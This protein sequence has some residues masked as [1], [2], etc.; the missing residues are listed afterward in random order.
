MQ[1]NSSTLPRSISKPYTMQELG[2]L[3]IRPRPQPK[4]CVLAQAA[5]PSSIDPSLYFCHGVAIAVYVDD[6]VMIGQ[7]E[8]E[9]NNI[10][11]AISKEFKVTDEGELTRFLGINVKR[12]GNKL[13]CPSQP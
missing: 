7:T 4:F 11:K 2:K 10:V 5:K 12:S 6:V 3:W 13:S 9:L 8:K 1:N